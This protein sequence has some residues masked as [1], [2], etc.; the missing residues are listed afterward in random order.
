MWAFV[1]PLYNIQVLCYSRASRRD[2]RSVVHLC[3]LSTVVCPSRIASS[4]GVRA[5]LGT[6]DV[7][8]ARIDVRAM[9]MTGREGRKRERRKAT[10]PRVAEQNSTLVPRLRRR[11]ALLPLRQLL[12]T[13]RDVDRLVNRVDRDKV[14]VADEGDGATDGSCANSGL[15]EIQLDWRDVEEQYI[16]SGVT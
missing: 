9:P 12:L 16:P 4:V 1:K 6:L 15:R 14:A 13:E 11:P 2:K 8:S 3:R 10:H 7:L 5:E